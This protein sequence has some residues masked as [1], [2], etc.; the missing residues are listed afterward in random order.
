MNLDEAAFT[1]GILRV[2]FA[3]NDVMV[4]EIVKEH[5]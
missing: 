1:D 4:K 2:G 3:A 5:H